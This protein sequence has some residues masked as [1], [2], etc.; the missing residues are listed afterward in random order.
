MKL[1]T[2]LMLSS[3]GSLVACSNG[4]SV[5]SSAATTAPLLSSFPATSNNLRISL[6][7]APSRKLKSVFVN[8]DHAELFVSK[9]GAN[10]RLMVAQ[11]LGL[12]DLMTLRNGVLLP[13]QDLNLAA[14]VQITGIRLVLKGDNNHAIKSDNSRCEMQTPSGQQSGIK[15]HLAQPFTLENDSVYSMIM[16]FDAEKSVVVKGNGGCLLKPVLKLMRVT[17]TVIVSDPPDSSDDDDG[18]V[19]S[20]DDGSNDDGSVG[21]GDTGSDDGIIVIDPITD[22]TDTNTD[23]NTGSDPGTGTDTGGGG[24]EIPLDPIDE[25][26]VITSESTF[27]L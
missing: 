1:G 5:V 13:M 26:A 15:I 21:S 11:D 6:T 12:V 14:G 24:F 4:S 22:G 7:D 20:G 10:G 16:D 18:S 3:L 23:T 19:G 27:S 2:I 8:I 17:K 25:P 9:G